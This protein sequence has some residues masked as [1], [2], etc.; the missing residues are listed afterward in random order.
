M[1]DGTGGGYA[2]MLG[3]ASH[4]HILERFIEELHLRTR[5]YNCLIRAGIKTVGDLTQRT[6]QDLRRISNFGRKSLGEIRSVLS[7]WG[8]TLTLGPAPPKRR[9]VYPARN[10]AIRASQEPYRVL[11][12][13]FAVSQSRIEQIRNRERSRERTFLRR[14]H[15]REEASSTKTK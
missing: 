5:P 7:S 15:A 6:E 1:V 2:G 4:G 12:A 11:A 3:N 8:L 9:E 10:A 13:R 14:R